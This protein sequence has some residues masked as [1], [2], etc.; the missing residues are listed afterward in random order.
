MALL[1]SGFFSFSAGAATAAAFLAAMTDVAA[2][3]ADAT[4][5]S[6]SFFSSAGAEMAITAIPDA[7]DAAMDADAN[8]ESLII[9]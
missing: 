5:F 1:S 9:R 6:G 3:A 2:D 4:A 8:S 7:L